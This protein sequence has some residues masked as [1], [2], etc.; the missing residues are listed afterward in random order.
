[1]RFKLALAFSL[2]IGTPSFGLFTS[3]SAID[4]SKATQANSTAC[5]AKQKSGAEEVNAFSA[6]A[7]R[8]AA[9][10]AAR[11]A[12]AGASATPIAGKSS[13]TVA[14]EPQGASQAQTRPSGATTSN[15]PVSAPKK[16]AKSKTSNSK[17]LG[18]KVNT[19]NVTISCIKSGKT[20][21]V[22]GTKPNC[23]KGFKLK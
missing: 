6:L 14:N 21:K 2:I 5:A 11:A 4:C 8:E 10:A 12:A 16:A 23:P 13:N 17:A 19:K 18:K 22:I 9:K 1:M 20:I 7:Q 3:A 15:A